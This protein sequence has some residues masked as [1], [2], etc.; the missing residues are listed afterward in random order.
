[1][2]RLDC[3]GRIKQAERS[4]KTA[5]QTVSAFI[6]LAEQQPELVL[7]NDLNLPELRALATELHTVFFARMFACFE[8]SLRHYW[9]T[10]VR[11]TRPLTR[12]LLDS[13]AGR[14]GV[15]LDTLLTVHEIREFRNYLMHEEH[16]AVKHFTIDGAIGQLNRYLARLPLEW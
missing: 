13:I 10:S 16:E 3:H 6:A 2:H 12:V 8:S 11:E 4:Y 15:P 5:L 14:R 1:M 9:W 7:D